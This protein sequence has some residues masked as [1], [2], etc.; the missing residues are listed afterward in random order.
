MLC[1]NSG[2]EKTFLFESNT[3]LY[4]STDSSP[5]DMHSYELC[6]DT[7]DLVFD[8]AVLYSKKNNGD[9]CAVIKLNNGMVVYA[10]QVNDKLTLVSLLRLEDW[11]KGLVEYNCSSVCDSIVEVLED[12]HLN[13]I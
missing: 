7:L 9:S 11:E 4:I 6:S 13:T 8:M 1:S 10:R 12:E 2:I 3:K 5:V